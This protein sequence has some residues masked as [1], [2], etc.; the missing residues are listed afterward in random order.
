[1]APS[2][3]LTKLKPFRALGGLTLYAPSPTDAQAEAA[4]NEE[5]QVYFGRG[6]VA[7]H[8]GACP[9]LHPCRSDALTPAWSVPAPDTPS[10]PCAPYN[11]TPRPR[12]AT[13]SS[14]WAPT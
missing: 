11:S 8:E 2:D 4:S 10:H 3:P 13:S 12:Q 9:L 5:A 6:A 1:M 7:L 14:T